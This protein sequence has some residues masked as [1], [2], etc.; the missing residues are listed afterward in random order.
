MSC[1][2]SHWFG[3]S[4]ADSEEEVQEQ[5]IT[6]VR[7]LVHGEP[8]S[9]EQIFS[10]GGILFHAI[11]KQLINPRPDVSLQV[12]SH[13]I[14][15]FLFKIIARLLIKELCPRYKSLKERTRLACTWPSWYICV[16]CESVVFFVLEIRFSKTDADFVVEFS[17]SLCNQQRGI[18]E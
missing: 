2:Q 3:S 10:D 7:N 5:A 15:L 12:W 4:L 18:W 13:A 6:L 9:I 14:L 11:E 8:D 1:A 17:G 16:I